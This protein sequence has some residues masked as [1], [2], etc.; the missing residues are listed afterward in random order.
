MTSLTGVQAWRVDDRLEPGTY[1]M[2]LFD[3]ERKQSSKNDPQ[4]VMDWRVAAGDFKGAEQRD[5]MT[6]WGDGALGN[7]VQILDACEIAV[8]EEEFKDF[9][10]M[11]DWFAKVLGAFKGRVEAVVRQGESY[12]DR[13]GELREGGP[14]IAGYR[15]PGSGSDVPEDSSDFAQAPKTATD[16]KAPF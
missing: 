3:V 2:T 5:W 13:D 14:K 4:V 6:F 1:L 9:A 15:R 11:A 12:T 7:V 8:P 16:D 10:G